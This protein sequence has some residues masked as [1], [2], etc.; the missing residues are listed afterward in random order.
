MLEQYILWKSIIKLVSFLL[1]IHCRTMCVTAC[2]EPSGARPHARSSYDGR[3]GHL[4]QVT[5]GI[6]GKT[7]LLRFK[8]VTCHCTH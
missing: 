5:K 7:R 4:L 1:K 6:D 8:R 3:I 2:R